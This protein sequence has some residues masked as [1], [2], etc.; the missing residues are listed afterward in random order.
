MSTKLFD[1]IVFGPV[2]S[3]RLGISLGVNL[4]PVDGKV[5]SFDCIYCECGYNAQGR[6]KRGLPDRTDVYKALDVRLQKMYENKEKLDV[7]TFAGNGE[8]TLHPQFGEII[9]D[10][11]FLRDK[12]FPSAKVSVLSNAT[13]IAKKT[14]F[15]ALSKVDNNILKLDSAN[16]ETIALLNAPN[17]V[18]FS[19]EE[20]IDNLKKFEGNLIVQTLFVRGCH[21]EKIVD[22]TTEKEID[23]WVKAIQKINPRQ[24]MIYTI[25]RETPEK[26]LEK[27]SR[28]ELEEIAD[29][30]RSLGYEVSVSA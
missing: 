3:R 21:Q 27:I 20:L 30:V 1:D 13:C 17:A 15:D 12:W 4:L 28:K 11:L 23:E 24:V 14:V 18:N 22:N 16:R 29:R 7:I 10:T 19:V 2:S 6:G 25:D 26:N 8:P 9:D 5:C